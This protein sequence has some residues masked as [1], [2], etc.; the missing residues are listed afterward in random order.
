MK[1]F[2]KLFAAGCA[3][4]FAACSGSAER[5]FAIVVDSAT[6]A[7]AKGEID[8]YAAAIEKYNGMNTT[9]VEDVWG[10]S[11]SVRM[12]IINLYEQKSIEGFALVGDVPVAMIRDA[13]HMTSAFKMDQ[14]AERIDSSVPSDRY[15]DDIDLKFTAL[16]KEEGKPYFYYSL[17]FDSPQRL[18]PE[19]YSGRIR[20]MTAEGEVDIDM[21]KAYLEKVVAE[22]ASG[23]KMDHT[24]FFSGHGYISESIVARMDEQEGIYDHFPWLKG[25]QDCVGYM[26]HKQYHPVKEYYMN[27]LMR[28]EID[29]AISHHHGNWDTQYFNGMPEVLNVD[30]DIDHVKKYCRSKLQ[31]AASHGRSTAALMQNYQKSAGIPRAWMSD[32]NDP[33]V[34]AEDEAF[35]ASLDVGLEDFDTYEFKPNAR[36]VLI[37]ACYCGSFHREF[38]IASRYIFNEGKS[39]AVIANSVN[40]LQDKWGD[41]LVGLIGLGMPVGQLVRYNPYLESHTVGD[42]TL[43]FVS[44]DEDYNVGDML[45][46]NTNWHK[47]LKSEYADIQALAM[48]ELFREGDITSS[49]LLDMFKNSKAGITRVV[50]LELLAKVGGAD[51]VEAVKLGVHDSY[52]LAQRFALKWVTRSGD[53]TF[54]DS[55]IEIAM[56]N[57]TSERINFNVQ[58]ALSVYPEAPLL[59]S[60]DRLFNDESVKYIHKDE[61]G[62]VIRSVISS[63]ANHWTDDINEILAD[64]FGDTKKS[65][66]IRL[67]RNNGVHYRFAE[68]LD[69][70]PALNENQQWMLVEAVGWHPYSYLKDSTIEKLKSI[71]ENEDLSERVRQEALK[72]INRLTF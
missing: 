3:L 14:T 7:E 8:A 15:Y 43:T 72:S 71:S 69:R 55:V 48:I 11:D 45:A 31:Y 60:F 58:Y 19:M 5:N 51:F 13:Q 12:A 27:E 2:N 37:D 26:D 30:A 22:K 36:L 39:I 25:Q 4:L 16:G 41:K 28:E 42:P 53:P 64:G 23:N 70:V 29:Y 57:N 49:E 62:K 67:L 10:V 66:Q 1:R 59:E 38:S 54:I 35:D 6:Y 50:A 68:L 61:V 20:P 24:F 65:Y 34:M 9:I 40:V 47:E 32:F 52:E 56:A 33:K 18:D 17:D 21:L 63:E 44:A 46:S